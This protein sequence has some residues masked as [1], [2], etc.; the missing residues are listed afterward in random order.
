[1]VLAAHEHG[2]IDGDA[3][4]RLEALDGFVARAAGLAP[5]QLGQVHALRA[6]LLEE[7]EQHDAAGDAWQLALA[8]DSATPTTS[9]SPVGTPLVGN[10]VLKGL[11]EFK[12]CLEV[13]VSE[14][15]C[16]RGAVQ[17]LLDLDRVTGAQSLLDATAQGLPSAPELD[18]WVMV[19]RGEA[20]QA[21]NLLAPIVASLDEET[22]G[23]R[24]QAGLTWYVLGLALGEGEDKV[25]DKALERAERLF[26][27]SADPLDGVLAARA[28]AARAEFGPASDSRARAREAVELSET[29]PVVHVHI[30]RA[31]ESAGRH[32]AAAQH[33]DKAAK[34]GPRTPWSTTPGASTTTTRTTSTERP[35][36]GAATWISGPPAQ[37]ADRVRQ[38][39]DR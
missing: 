22:P 8:A 37:R 1:M 24:A 33:F 6:E 39:L 4:A 26:S 36:R 30:G 29:D 13:R 27:G 34:L 7:L 10:Q 2:W 21:K 18:A 3:Q 12:T 32:S 9:T 25:A 5:R 28:A 19:R 31:Y 38:R 16:R 35:R 14:A 23:K 15:R 11:Q 20:E 17:A